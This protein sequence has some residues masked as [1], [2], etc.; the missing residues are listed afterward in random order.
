M[1]GIE[2]KQNMAR[3]LDTLAHLAAQAD[4][5]AAGR[6]LRGP[7]RRERPD[8]AVQGRDRRAARNFLIFRLAASGITA[9]VCLR[10]SGTEPKAKA[11]IEVGARADASRARR[12]RR[13]AAIR[14]S[15]DAQVQQLATDF[16]TLAM[17]TVGQV[18]APG[19]DKLS[20]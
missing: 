16:L 17:A 1:T 13:G 10:P 4:R 15:V 3:M 9:K 2:G 18:P 14:Q 6:R 7:A 20:R 12:K 5:R 19:A 11:Y 8:G